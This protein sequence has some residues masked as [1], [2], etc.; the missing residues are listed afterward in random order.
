MV[1]AALKKDPVK[2]W[3]DACKIV[4]DKIIIFLLQKKIS[5]GYTE[6]SMDYQLRYPGS[7][8]TITS[9]FRM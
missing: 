3:I 9:R 2:T 6:R 5:L 4:F 8:T 1:R 7:N